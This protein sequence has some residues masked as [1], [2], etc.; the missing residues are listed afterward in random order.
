MR[1][2][3]SIVNR[4]AKHATVG[5]AM[6]KFFV[7]IMGSL[8]LSVAACKPV[9]A[10]ET[11][12][13]IEGFNLG[14]YASAGIVL[15][16]DQQAEAAANE[17]SLIL[18]WVGDGRLSFFGELELERPLAW[19]D[20]K[21]FSRKEGHL[22]LERLYFDYNLSEKVNFRAGRFLTPNS[23]WNLL[24]AS[25]LV[26]T[27]TRPLA[28]SQLFPTGTNGAMLFGALPFMNGAFEY[29]LFGEILEDQEQDGD[30]LKFE[31]VRGARF[32][33]KN[34]SDIGISLLSFS[35][36]GENA[37]SY[38][39]L[40]LDF[41]SHIKDIEISGEA[42]QRFNIN[43]KDGGSGAYLQTAIP[44]NAVGLNDWYCVTRLETFQRPDEGASE[45]WLLGAT[46]RVKPTQLLKLEFTG[47]SKDQPE[48]P[49][50]FLASFA[51]FF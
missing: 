27:S 4:R 35:E 51:L 38:R 6:R 42:F 17:V 18:T 23:S 26:W 24:H 12:S 16:R 37:A 41:V 46:W 29:K 44:L 45:R 30:E 19:S 2:L 25:P 5:C 33:Y 28:T 10:E 13:F 40:G 8:A 32:S 34:Q 15:H 14:G 21:K 1:Q 47:G 20:D 3:L 7:F 31:H 39:M 36:K 11:P 49:R 9:V 43:N 48:S 22:D 50:G